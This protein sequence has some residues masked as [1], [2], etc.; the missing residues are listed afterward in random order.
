MSWDITF[1]RQGRTLADWLP[2]L[3]SPDTNVQLQAAEAIDAM[4]HGMDS[5]HS[6]LETMQGEGPGRD[7]G[8]RFAAEME[9]A[10]QSVA[11]PARELIVP[12]ASHLVESDRTHR[13]HCDSHFKAADAH[14]ERIQPMVESITAELANTTDEARKAELRSRLTALCCS[15]PELNLAGIL[16]EHGMSLTSAYHFVIENGGLRLLECPD[17][18]QAMLDQPGTVYV[19]ERALKRLGSRASEWARHFLHRL[20]DASTDFYSNQAELLAALGR[21]IPW[22]IDALGERLH[23]EKEVIRSRAAMTLASVAP[24]LAGRGPTLFHKLDTLY[25]EGSPP[26]QVHYFDA[27]VSLG[28]EQVAVRQAVYRQTLP[29]QSR[30]SMNEQL[31]YDVDEAMVERAHAIS[32]CHYLIDWPEELV[33]VL[34]Q[35]LGNFEDYDP[36]MNYHGRDNRVCSVLERLGPAALVALPRILELLNAWLTKH[37]ENDVEP[38]DLLA[39]VATFGPAAVSALPTLQKMREPD[40]VAEP[41][42]EYHPVDKAIIAVQRSG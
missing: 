2:D 33:P 18:I 17:M 35:S 21:G 13:A 19:V 28:R 8:E 9:L 15:G 38:G 20:D 3:V 42:D 40:R 41:L 25:R 1:V 12:V 30:V 14:A 36:D 32:A 10:I 6:D 16:E 5:I 29:Q 24:D 37:D 7:H 26:G 4:H 34:I 11:M 23:R 22:V 31:G 27:W 39:L